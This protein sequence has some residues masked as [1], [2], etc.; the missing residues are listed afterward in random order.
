MV[1]PP[2]KIPPQQYHCRNDT[3][4]H[5][6]NL[7]Y[8]YHDANTSWSSSSGSESSSRGGRSSSGCNSFATHEQG[9]CI[10]CG[11]YT[12]RMV[13]TRTMKPLSPLLETLL[14]ASVH[15]RWHF[16][17]F[18]SRL[19]IAGSS[20]STVCMH[21]WICLDK[22]I[23]SPFFAHSVVYIFACFTDWTWW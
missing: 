10:E 22:H 18:Q 16:E 23:S 14:R 8:H 11:N 2:P 19:R 6:N 21:P 7:H 12:L 5:S 13:D 20:C 4:I 3:P 9:K 15:A 1:P 17:S